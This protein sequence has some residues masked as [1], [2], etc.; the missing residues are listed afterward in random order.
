[1]PVG[2]TLGEEV[3]E[4]DVGVLVAGFIFD[5]SM[6]VFDEKNRSDGNSTSQKVVESRNAGAGEELEVVQGRLRSRN[7]GEL[8]SPLLHEPGLDT[9]VHGD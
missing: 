8:G 6:K 7:S 3:F 1:M 2:R 4:Q 5:V 9:L